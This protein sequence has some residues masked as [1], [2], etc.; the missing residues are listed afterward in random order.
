MQQVSCISIRQPMEKAGKADS[1]FG[2]GTENLHPGAANVSPQDGSNNC[3]LLNAMCD[4]L[5][6]W[7]MAVAVRYS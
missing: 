6:R 4:L 1:C 5:D 7:M 2:V 3:S